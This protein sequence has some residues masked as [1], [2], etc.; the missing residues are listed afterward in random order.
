LFIL[1]KLQEHIDILL[2]REYFP[3]LRKLTIH[4]LLGISWSW[5]PVLNPVTATDCER[6]LAYMLGNSD[7]R[8]FNFFIGEWDPYVGG[9]PVNW[10]YREWDDR[11]KWST[12]ELRRGEVLIEGLRGVRNSEVR[13][14]VW[15]PRTP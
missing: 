4:T 12:K 1:I 15:M 6:L 5:E 9:L 10:V 3:N 13:E 11:M 7:I 2:S 8:E 14:L